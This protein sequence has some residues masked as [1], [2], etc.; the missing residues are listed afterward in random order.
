MPN[1]APLMEGMEA[2]VAE[3][4]VH[5]QCLAQELLLHDRQHIELNLA[6]G[7]AR[8]LQLIAIHQQQLNMQ[9]DR[10]VID[11]LLEAD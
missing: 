1:L 4:N 8:G 10:I 5:C 11:Q 2:V 3:I 9:L 6:A 7:C